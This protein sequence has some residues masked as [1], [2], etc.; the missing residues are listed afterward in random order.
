MQD[1]LEVG[2]AQRDKLFIGLTGRSQQ[3]DIITYLAEYCLFH[4]LALEGA[5]DILNYPIH[6]HAN[7]L[8]PNCNSCSAA[9]QCLSVNTPI[10]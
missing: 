3:S 1:L 10:G 2:L 5:Q 6:K 4:H 7:Q 8:E 9:S